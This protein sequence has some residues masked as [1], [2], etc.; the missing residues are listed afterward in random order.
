MFEFA[1]KDSFIVC[2]RFILWE[3]QL[4]AQAFHLDGMM[5]KVEGIAWDSIRPENSFKY[6]VEYLP[7]WWKL[8]KMTLKV[9]P[10]L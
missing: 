6:K 4:I 7:S 9:Y 10:S 5:K 8:S 1:G 3:L 2:G